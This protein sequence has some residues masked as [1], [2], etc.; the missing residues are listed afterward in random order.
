MQV[1]ILKNSINTKVNNK[2]VKDCYFNILYC[3]IE[4]LIYI[5]TNKNIKKCVK[6][7]FNIIE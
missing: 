1:L 7:M 5:Q 4:Y 3:K 6:N 2:E